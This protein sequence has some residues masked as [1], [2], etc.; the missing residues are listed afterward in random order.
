MKMKILKA[1]TRMAGKALSRSFAHIIYTQQKRLV[2]VELRQGVVYKT[3]VPVKP[4]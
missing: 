4:I 1:V 2:P 3:P